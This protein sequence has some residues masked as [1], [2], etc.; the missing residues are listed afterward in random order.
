MKKNNAGNDVSENLVMLTVVLACI[1]GLFLF[2]GRGYSCLFVDDTVAVRA[3]EAQGMKQ[4]KVTGHAYSFVPWRGGSDSD[5][6]RYDCEAVNPANQT[7]KMYVFT[8]MF[9]KGATVRTF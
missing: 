5:R 9:F 8:G 3:L 1:F 2:F 4:V 6:I 7:V